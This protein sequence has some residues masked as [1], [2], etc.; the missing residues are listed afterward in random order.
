MTGG[1]K[2]AQFTVIVDG[3]GSHALWT[4][5]PVLHKQQVCVGF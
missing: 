4:R 3:K 1:A 2:I 5:A